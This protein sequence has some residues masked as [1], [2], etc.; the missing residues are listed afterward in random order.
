MF[1]WTC[2]VVA[3]V[4]LSV[5]LWM[6]NDI[7][8]QVRQSAAVVDRAGRTI[9]ND[10]PDIVERSRKTSEA[11]AKNLPEVVDKVRTATDTVSKSLPAVIDRIEKTTEV[12]AELAVDIRRLKEL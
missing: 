2:L 10:L 8:L 12:V 4:F 3:V 5:V 6:I 9:N 7:R 11:I 1:K